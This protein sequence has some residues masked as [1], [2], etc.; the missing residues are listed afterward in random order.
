MP[1]SPSARL[2]ALTRDRY[3]VF[4]PAEAAGVDVGR[5]QIQRM[6]QRGELEELLPR[7]YGLVAVPD[8]WDRRALAALKGGGAGAVLSHGA[9]ARLLGLQHLGLGSHPEIELT[10]PLDRRPRE[11]RFR[12]HA[13]A[14]LEPDDVA[15]LGCFVVTGVLF[16]I[17][18]M[19]RRRAPDR[20]AKSLDAAIVERRA[21]LTETREL[22]IRMWHTPGVVNLRQALA[23]VTPGAAL[24]RSERERCYLRICRVFDLPLPEVN[25]RVEDAN[26]DRRYADFLYRKEGLIIEINAH[27]SHATTLGR[28]LDGSR[29]NALVPRFVVLN[30]DDRD[31]TQ[32]PERIATEVRRALDECSSDRSLG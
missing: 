28:R 10:Y 15:I 11:P 21:T 32:E 1:T 5:S 13:S 17:G 19:A 20:I 4:T 3:G 29:Q 14:L 26:G 23:L 24:T 22:T 7:V 30:Y 2:A 16:T 27:T 31:L 12:T 6:R 18:A 25:A 8:S 9:A